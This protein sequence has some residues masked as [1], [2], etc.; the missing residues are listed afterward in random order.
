MKATKKSIGAIIILCASL[1]SFICALIF[2]FDF[3]IAVVITTVLDVI[4]LCLLSSSMTDRIELIPERR[5]KLIHYLE[6]YL[7]EGVIT[8]VTLEYQ[9]IYGTTRIHTFKNVQ[10]ENYAPNSYSPGYE[11]KE[12]NVYA[13]CIYRK[14]GEIFLRKE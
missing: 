2:H 14:G 13:A 1:F 3:S 6:E 9:D 4:G 12:G 7:G 8:Y 5:Y 11:P 10:F